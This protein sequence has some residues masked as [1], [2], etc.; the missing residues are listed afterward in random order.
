MATISVN[1]YTYAVQVLQF[2]SD[3]QPILSISTD[4]GHPRTWIGISRYFFTPNNELLNL[5]DTYEIEPMREN[6]YCL[7]LRSWL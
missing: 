2:T 1:G 4:E 7:T 3:G 5:S 6:I